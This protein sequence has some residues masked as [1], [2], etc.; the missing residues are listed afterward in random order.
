VTRNRPSFRGDDVNPYSFGEIN[1]T[2]GG[3]DQGARPAGEVPFGVAILAD[4]GGRGRRGELESVGDRPALLIDRDNF[5]E[6]LAKL[7]VEMQLP[8]GGEHGPTRLA[9]SELDDFHPG[10]LY[11]RSEMFERLRTLRSRLSD[12]SSFPSAAAELGLATVRQSPAKPH[13]AEKPTPTAVS[14]AHTAKGSLLDESV[15]HTEGGGA[16]QGPRRAP[17]QL[18][19]F[20]RRVTEPHL[21]AASDERQAEVLTVLDRAASMQMRALLHSPDFQAL[22]ASWRALFFLVRRIETSSQLKLYL[23]DISK[24]ELARDLASSEDL[25]ST[26]VY[27]TLVEKSVGT[28]GSE[29]WAVILGNYSFGP[30]RK[31]AELLGRMAG[32]ARAA[33]APFIAGASSRLLGSPSFASAAHPRKWDMHQPADDAAAWTELR[34]LPE[35]DAVGLALPRFLLRLPYGEKT[36]GVESFAFEEMHA[37]A[38]HEDYLWGNAAF[39][40][41]LLLAESFRRDGWGMRPG[42][43]SEIDRLPLHAYEQSGESE[44]QPCAEAL[45]TDEA[46]ER[47]LEK[48]LMPLLSLKGRD[49]VRLARFQSIA[50]PPRALAGP[51]DK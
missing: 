51:W 44:L 47:I 2:A 49:L 38:S 40:C 17:D 15:E 36:A 27:R 30:S 33:G 45:L 29:P 14:I 42:V 35:A 16:N 13:P 34:R 20:V 37:T 21:V 39:A 23:I 32:I 41:G 3:D 11:E 31:D 50:Q 22:E 4:F 28:P 26:G 12:P 18:Q 24:Q 43:L 9:F 19:D 46:I 10:R 48:G 8:Q 5:D 7:G 1:L 25:R 6:V